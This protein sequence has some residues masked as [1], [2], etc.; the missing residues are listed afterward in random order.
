[1]FLTGKASLNI[2]IG[3]GY[4]IMSLNDPEA[5][6]AQMHP[7]SPIRPF[8]VLRYIVQYYVSG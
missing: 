5:R 4:N 7:R 1:M 8:S 6:Y 2:N 3:I